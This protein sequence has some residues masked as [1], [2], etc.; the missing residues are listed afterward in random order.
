MSLIKNGICLPAWRNCHVM[1]N[2][3]ENLTDELDKVIKWAT[4]NLFISK[5][6]NKKTNLQTYLF[7]FM[8]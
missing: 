7:F 1:T 6:Y 3:E 4:R 2:L 8:I 5:K